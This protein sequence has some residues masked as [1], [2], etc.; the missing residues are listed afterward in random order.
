MQ[1]SDIPTIRGSLTVHVMVKPSEKNKVVQNT[2]STLRPWK[3][4]LENVESDSYLEGGDPE[5]MLVD[6]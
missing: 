3:N 5:S 1:G 4:E 2:C 6:Q